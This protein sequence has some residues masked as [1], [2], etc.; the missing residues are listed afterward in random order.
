MCELTDLVVEY[1][2]KRR[3]EDGELPSFSTGICGSLTCGYGKLDDYGYWE[4]PLYDAEEISIICAKRR[5]QG[6]L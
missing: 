2:A 5:K 1:E 3:W 4:F 6:L